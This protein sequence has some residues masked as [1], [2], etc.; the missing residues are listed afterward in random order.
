MYDTLKSNNEEKSAALAERRMGDLE[1]SEEI[2]ARVVEMI[3]ATKTHVVSENQD[4]NYFTDA[5]LSI[6][7]KDWEVYNQYAKQ[8]RSEYAIYSDLLYNPGRKKVLKH[9]L[10]MNQIYKTDY[11]TQKYEEQARLNLSRELEGDRA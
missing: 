6:L 8:V 5:D 2:V 3:L 11:F 1:V 4:I 9:F 7:G 10:A